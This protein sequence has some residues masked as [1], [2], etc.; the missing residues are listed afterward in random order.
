MKNYNIN[1]SI[2]G[3]TENLNFVYDVMSM[4]SIGNDF[5]NLSM[6]LFKT[7]FDDPMLLS[8]MVSGTCELASIE[9]HS[10]TVNINLTS[11]I[12]LPFGWLHAFSY[13]FKGVAFA[14]YTTDESGEKLVLL[15]GSGSYQGG[16]Y[17]PDI[18]Y[19]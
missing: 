16:G 19:E 8:M 14:V 6:D 5:I 2:S 1:I 4:E 13:A 10:S 3:S 18:F 15:Y 12:P 17:Y 9:H 11:A 7:T